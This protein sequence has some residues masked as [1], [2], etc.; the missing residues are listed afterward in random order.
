MKTFQLRKEKPVLKKE[1]RGACCEKKRH[2]VSIFSTSWRKGIGRR[3][4]GE[5]RN[6]SDTGEGKKGKKEGFLLERKQAK[7]AKRRR[8]ISSHRDGGERGRNVLATLWREEENKR[9]VEKKKK[10]SI[11][12]S[13]LAEGGK[14]KSKNPAEKKGR[15]QSEWWNGD[16]KEATY[17]LDSKRGKRKR[18]EGPVNQNLLLLLREGTK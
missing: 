8:L 12:A 11:I 18:R 14:K 6:F 3:R 10:K 17:L 2:S 7:E 16:G 1:R 15:T 9:K 5:E 4:N 13:R